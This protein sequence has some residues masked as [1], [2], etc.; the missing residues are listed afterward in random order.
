[1][2]AACAAVGAV[3][4]TGRRDGEAAVRGEARSSADGSHGDDSF[5]V[6]AAGAS[7]TIH[8]S[9]AVERGRGVSRPALVIFLVSRAAVWGLA[10]TT[11]VLFRDRLDPDRAPWDTP[12]LHELGA[13]L[14]VLARWDSNWFLK[15]AAEGYSWPSATPAFFP[16][17]PLLTGGLGRLLGGHYLAAGIAVAVSAGAVAFALLHRLAREQLGNAAATRS[18]LFLALTP[19]SLFLGAVYSESLF[20]ALAVCCF[21]LAEHGRLGAAA[22]VAGLALLTRPQGIALLAALAVLAWQRAGRARALAAVGIASALFLAYP[23][24]LW[25]W[26]ERPLA[27]L[28][29][30]RLWERHLSPLGPLGGLT[31][32]IG[33]GE[34]VE[35]G[36][37][38]AAVFLTVIAW[39]RLGPAYGVYAGGVIA[40]AMSFP[41]ERLGGLYSFPRLSLVAFPCFMALGAVTG[42]RSAP[43]LLL[44]SGALLAVYVVRWALWRWVS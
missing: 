11:V 7:A 20:L 33:R 17:Y 22:G 15:I 16:L 19:M 27:F 6:G 10:A 31:E 34:L 32:A 1:M 28:D 29:A 23:L 5:G 2:A 21:L 39:R 24:L 35:L 41:S 44:A 13:A 8:Y 18:V 36:F 9:G 40:L 3:A 43:P 4:A 37:A 42:R 26:I 12:R 14:D 25:A 38:A 30:E